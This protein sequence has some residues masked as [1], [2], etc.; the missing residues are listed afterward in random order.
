[1]KLQVEPI[2]E[3]V[4]ELLGW[5]VAECRTFSLQMLREIIRDKDRKLADDISAVL[6]GEHHVLETVRKPRRH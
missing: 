6:Y 4:A 2:Y 3:R 1:M 5:T